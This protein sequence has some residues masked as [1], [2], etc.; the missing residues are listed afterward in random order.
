MF[1]LSITIK[2]MNV[3]TSGMD[4]KSFKYILF[5]FWSQ[6]GFRKH[7]MMRPFNT[8]GMSSLLNFDENNDV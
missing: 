3:G 7:I 4:Y 6:I 1:N 2:F 5:I 8:R